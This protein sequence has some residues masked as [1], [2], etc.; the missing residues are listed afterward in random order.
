VLTPL[1]A[2]PVARHLG[3]NGPRPSGQRVSATE[4]VSRVHGGAD[5]GASHLARG[6]WRLTGAHV[7][8]LKNLGRPQA[9]PGKGG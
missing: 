7:A 1:V 8:P 3:T 5:D 4:M 6:E 9:K 2:F